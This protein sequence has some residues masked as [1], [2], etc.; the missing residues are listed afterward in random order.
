MTNPQ[1]IRTLPEAAYALC[2]AFPGAEETVSHERPDYKVGG[3]SFATF[4]VNHHGDGRVAFWLAMP[5][6]GGGNG[7]TIAME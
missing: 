5:P 6:E 7:P 1:D 3:K 4:M 2:M